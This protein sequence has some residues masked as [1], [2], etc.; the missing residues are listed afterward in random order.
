MK[1]FTVFTPTY[2]REHTLTKLYSSLKKQT[3]QDF[4]W[5]IVDDGSVDKTREL[6]AGWLNENILDIKYIYQQ[7]AGKQIAYN[8]GIDEGNSELFVCIDSDD[9]YINNGFE[10]IL[11]YWNN[12]KDKERY[13]G[14]TFLSS[15]PDGKVIGTHFP[16]DKFVSTHFDIYHKYHVIGDKGMMFRTSIL[17][18]NKFPV[19]KGVKYQQEAILYHR[20]DRRYKTLFVNEIIE[21]KD[22]QKEGITDS[23]FRILARDCKAALVYYNELNFFDMSYS[24]LIRNNALYIKYSLFAG[25]NLKEIL[26]NSY[27]KFMTILAIPR[28]YYRYIRAQ[29]RLRRDK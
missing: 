21:V 28:G 7:N 4:E 22:Y 25:K 5:I 2:N 18:A 24:Q 14:V 17:K 26:G 9:Y 20:L 29:L 19:F 3:F 16:K 23:Y 1:K 8:R 13:V 27:N 12:I 10:L 6:V 11:N 15:Y